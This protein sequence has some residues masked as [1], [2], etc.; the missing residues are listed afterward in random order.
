MVPRMSMKEFEV[1]V[2]EALDGLP[3]EFQELLENV[4]VRVEDEPEDEDFEFSDTDGDEELLGV[5]R[6]PMRTE[7]GL[8]VLPDLPSQVV[9][10]RG[11]ILRNTQSRREA[12]QEVQ[13]TV[14][15]ELGHF[16]GLEDE[17]M[18]Y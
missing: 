16:F 4:V 14:L 15:H 17:E 5:Y 2:A 3:G 6:G 12:I 18:P 10:F 1:L 11:P 13:D 8:D 7:Q 9:I